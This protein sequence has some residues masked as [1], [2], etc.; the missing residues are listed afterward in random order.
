MNFEPSKHRL[1]RVDNKFNDLYINYID[2][3]T[4]ENYYEKVTGFKNYFYY[5]DNDFGYIT[6]KENLIKVDIQNSW[7][8]SK[9]VQVYPI[10]YEGDI[11]LEKRFY[12]DMYRGVKKVPKVKYKTGVIDIEVDMGNIFDDSGSKPITAIS[13]YDIDKNKI[14]TFAHHKYKK[15]DYNKEIGIYWCDD[16]IEMLNMFLTYMGLSKYSIILGWNVWFDINYICKRL[17]RID[18]EK[19][20]KLT[21]KLSPFKVVQKAYRGDNYEIFGLTVIDYLNLY[22]VFNRRL[23]SKTVK[24]HKLNDVAIDELNETKVEF[25]GNLTELYNNNPDKYVEYNRMDVELVKKLEDKL[26]YLELLESINEIT[27]ENLEDSMSASI[28]LDTIFIRILNAKDKVVKSKKYG[29]EKEVYVGAFNFPVASGIYNTYI[30][31]FDVSSLYPSIMRMIN[32]SPDTVSDNGTIL[33]GSPSKFIDKPLGMMPQFLKWMYD[34]RMRVKGLMKDMKVEENKSGILNKDLY[35]NYDMIQQSTKILLNSLYG[36]LGYDKNRYYNTDLKYN[37]GNAVTTTGQIIIQSAGEFVKKRGF[38]IIYGDTDSLGITRDDMRI[39]TMTPEEAVKIGEEIREY[40]NI[41]VREVIY[42][43]F[44]S[45]YTDIFK[46]EFEKI[47]SGIH[48]FPKNYIHKVYWTEGFFNDKRKITLKGVASKK[49]DTTPFTAKLLNELYDIMLDNVDKEVI[50]KL[51]YDKI[52]DYR[53]KL[54]DMYN[55]DKYSLGLPFSINKDIKDYEKKTIH[56]EGAKYYNEYVRKGMMTKLERGSRGVYFFIKAVT[57]SLP[58]VDVLSIPEKTKLPEGF[59]IDIEQ[60]IVR[61]IDMKVENIIELIENGFVTQNEKD[62]A[63]TAEY[64]IKF[65]KDDEK[66]VDEIMIKHGYEIQVYEKPP[67]KFVHPTLF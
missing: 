14:F 13:I 34:E 61:L 51:I 42:K 66:L 38:K 9:K 12:L 31:T 10:T 36:T 21:E 48:F 22:K 28:G 52:K 40:L 20:L 35:D 55:N 57:N 56:V 7:E 3:K 58:M 37:L 46:M 25:E 64:Q 1:V 27:I 4:N 45:P 59:E 17:I 43:R 6:K 33:S 19:G 11:N 65:S 54:Y 5:A 44:N 18:T 67:E 16:E 39:D 23:K 15:K 63:D 29:V 32:I 49:A 26:K 53:N 30:M 2:V 8:K 41:C 60:T 62:L 47:S 24:S 50:K